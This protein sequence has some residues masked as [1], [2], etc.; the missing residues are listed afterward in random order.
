V[1]KL[2]TGTQANKK[3]SGAPVAVLKSGH[4]SVYRKIRCTA[5]SVGYAVRNNVDDTYKC[6]R[7]GA[8]VKMTSM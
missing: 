6:Q 1:A 2:I 3:K 4:A 5:C 7:C 8:T